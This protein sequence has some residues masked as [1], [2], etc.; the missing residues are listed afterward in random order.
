MYTCVQK[1]DTFNADCCAVAAS[2]MSVTDEMTRVD[3]LPSSIYESK[4]LLSRHE[5]QVRSVLEQPH[6]TWL[7]SN[8]ETAL[9]ELSAMIGD[10]GSGILFR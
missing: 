10:I 8:G 7:L 9:D 5:L 1:L 3:G 2:L 6:V 4:T